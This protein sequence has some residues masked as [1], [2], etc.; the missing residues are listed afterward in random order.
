MLVDDKK[1]NGPSNV[2][3]ADIQRERGKDGNSG[4]LDASKSFM[5]CTEQEYPRKGHLLH[6]SWPSWTL[7]DRKAFLL[8][9]PA[10]KIPTSHH[11]PFVFA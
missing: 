2:V 11:V 4:L 3:V 6:D 5:G 1:C 10:K 9:F 7:K 8:W